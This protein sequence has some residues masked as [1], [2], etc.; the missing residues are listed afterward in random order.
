MATAY[1]ASNLLQYPGKLG[2][3]GFKHKLPSCFAAQNPEPTCPAR[4]GRRSGSAALG[5]VASWT[6][7]LGVS[8]TWPCRRSTV[9]P[10]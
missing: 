7:E 4:R 2:V 10:Q 6:A 1:R 5:G 3:Q 9:L 8:G